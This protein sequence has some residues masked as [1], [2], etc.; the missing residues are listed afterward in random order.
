MGRVLA[1]QV[2][3]WD[4]VPNTCVKVEGEGENEFTKSSSDLHAYLLAC[5]PCLMGAYTY[6]NE[7]K[8]KVKKLWSKSC[9]RTVTVSQVFV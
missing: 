8:K 7:F 3:P 2:W 4:L 5:T 9:D 6:N 1:S